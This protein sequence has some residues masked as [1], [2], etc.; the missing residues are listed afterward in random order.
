MG[1]LALITVASAVACVMD[2]SEQSASG[3]VLLTLLPSYRHLRLC[4]PISLMSP[5]KHA[6]PTPRTPKPGKAAVAKQALKSPNHERQR[7]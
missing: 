1:C 6:L 7:A 3:L 5:E 4:L 2:H